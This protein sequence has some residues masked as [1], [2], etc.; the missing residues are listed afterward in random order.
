MDSN[1][2]Q[3]DPSPSVD[4]DDLWVRGVVYANQLHALAEAEIE[5]QRLERNV[6]RARYEYEIAQRIRD[7]M[8][9]P[10]AHKGWD[11]QASAMHDCMV[12]TEQELAEAVEK[13]DY[14]RAMAARS[15]PTWVT[16]PRCMRRS[17]PISVGARRTRIS[18]IWT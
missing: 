6:A 1:L 10:E 12:M 2:E 9:E 5:A 17:W 11:I 14:H 15:R 8:E 7:K 13:A 4:S 3:P 18:M 16:K